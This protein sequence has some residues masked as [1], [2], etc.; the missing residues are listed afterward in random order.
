MRR[1]AKIRTGS[2]YLRFHGLLFGVTLRGAL[3]V[4]KLKIAHT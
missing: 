3:N 4:N 2:E 1:A